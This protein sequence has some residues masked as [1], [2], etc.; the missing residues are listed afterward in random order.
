[1]RTKRINEEEEEE[2][3]NTVMLMAGNVCMTPIEKVKAK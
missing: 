3:N 2:A 1:V